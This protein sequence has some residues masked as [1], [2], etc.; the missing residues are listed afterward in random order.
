MTEADLL[1]YV[2]EAFEAL[3][4]DYMISG[5]QASI[6]YGEPRFT[7][8]IDIVADLD[9]AHVPGL[10]AR[11]PLPELYV[12]EDAAREA[13]ATRGQLNIIHPESGLR[14]DVIVRRD[15]PYDRVEFGRRQRLPALEGRDAYFARPEDVILYKMIYY[16]EGASER[17]FRAPTLTSSTSTNGRGVSI[18]ATSG[19]RYAGAS[20]SGD[21]MS[22]AH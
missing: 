13:V 9:V 5:S 8:D 17:Q 7:Q 21:T 2:V 14:I 6:Y 4:I 18:S 15:T 10:L 22:D 11:F 19:T 12:A 3:G 1:R 16:C 20:A